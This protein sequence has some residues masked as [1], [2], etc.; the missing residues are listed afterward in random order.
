MIGVWDRSQQGRIATWRCSDHAKKL[1]SARHY[2]DI[3]EIQGSTSVKSFKPWQHPTTCHAIWQ[4]GRTGKWPVQNLPRLWG[5]TWSLWWAPTW[6]NISQN[7]FA[8]WRPKTPNFEPARSTHP[9]KTEP[10]SNQKRK[11][12]PKHQ[13]Q[14]NQ[15]LIHLAEQPVVRWI[16]APL[17]NPDCTNH[18]PRPNFP[19]LHLHHPPNHS[20]TPNGSSNLA[21]RHRHQPNR[22]RTCESD[23]HSKSWNVK[24][25]T[26]TRF[27][28]SMR[29]WRPRSMMLPFTANWMNLPRSLKNNSISYPLV[30]N[31]ASTA[32]WWNGAWNQPEHPNTNLARP[33]SSCAFCT[34]FDSDY[35]NGTTV[36]PCLSTALS[37]RSLDICSILFAD[38]CP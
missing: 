6:Q 29:G 17:C 27:N 22:W 30:N 10:T 18:Q 34:R 26:T 24:D 9:S 36:S 12:V 14:M 3:Y 8:S 5:I 11:L 32:T 19:R 35:V 20:R 13:W 4:F 31:Q 1:F 37:Q 16:S 33:S 2:I 38:G 28:P 25:P 7:A 15:A 21:L 23:P